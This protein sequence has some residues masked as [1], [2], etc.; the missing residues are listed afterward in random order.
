MGWERQV[1]EAVR[2]D[3][4]ASLNEK[5]TFAVAMDLELAELWKL[6]EVYRTNYRN[7]QAAEAAFDD[8]RANQQVHFTYLAELKE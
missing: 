7:L 6:E 4:I 2:L 1:C 8:Q 5:C 3:V